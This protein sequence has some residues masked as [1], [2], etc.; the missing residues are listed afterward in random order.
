ML[1]FTVLGSGSTGNATLVEAHERLGVTRPTRL[2]VDCGFTLRELRRRMSERDLTLDDL[3]AVF[4]T[5]E[6]G[7]HVGCLASLVR[8][9]GLPV[10]TSAG[11]WRGSAARTAG[12]PAPATFAR[13]G[14]AI[15]VG[16]LELRPFAVS[17][18]AREP[19]QLVVDDG[20]RRLGIATDFGTADARVTHALQGCHALL[21][22]SN[23]DEAMLEH[24][25]Y[26]YSLRKRIAG[27]FGHLANT[28]AAALLAACRHD[29]LGR[30]VAA[31]LSRHNNIP[32][33]AAAA[34]ADV[35]GCGASDIDV[36]DPDQGTGWIA[37]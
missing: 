36:A 26:P 12:L 11:T 8:K 23:H 34:F 27:R 3:D 29:G 32:R 16:A 4:V 6:H 30:V 10:I 9:H 25:P 21:L 28:Q 14:E 17:H 1:R 31:H 15:V 19:L 33:L 37:A 13:D 18:D 22:E 2:L 5:H 24:G 35:M 20:A 7:D